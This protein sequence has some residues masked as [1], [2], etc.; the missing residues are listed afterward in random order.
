MGLFLFFFKKELFVSFGLLQLLNIPGIN[1]LGRY[2]KEHIQKNIILTYTVIVLGWGRQKKFYGI[3][4]D[5]EQKR[6][7]EA[8]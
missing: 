3:I 6:I 7:S 2:I 4:I 5:W 1:T 8:I